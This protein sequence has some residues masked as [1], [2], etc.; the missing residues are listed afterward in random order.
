V[1]STSHLLD[2]PGARLHLEVQG[3]GPT[4]L[5]V[6]HPMGALGFARLAPWLPTATRS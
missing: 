2:V 1:P 6:G 5:L 4:L 3:S